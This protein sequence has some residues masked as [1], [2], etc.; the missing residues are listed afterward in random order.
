V[1]R[2]DSSSTLPSRDEILR[3]IEANPEARK[4]DVLEA[5][6]VS[7]RDKVELKRALRQLEADGAIE[8][9]RRRPARRP[10]VARNEGE[11]PPVAVADVVAIDD[12]G[13]L[14]LRAAEQPAA[15][16]LLPTETLE[17]VA[18]RVGDRLL[19]RLRRK[20]SGSYEARLLKLL[21][22]LPREVAG[23][24]E[25][26]ADGLRLRPADRKS[27][28]EYRIA[29]GDA[30][31]AAPGDLVR[32]EVMPSRGY[33]L[34]R[35]K[36]IERLGR[37][38]EPKA[39]SLMVA[40][41]AELPMA[42]SP[43]A[44]AQAAEAKPVELGNRTDLRDVPLVTIDGEDARDFDDAVWAAADDDPANAG[45]HRL[46]VAIADVAWYVRPEDPLDHAAQERGNSVYFPDRVIPML[47][48]ALSNDLCS[49][50]PNEDR[51][52]MAVEM[53]IDSKGKL[54]RHR[55]MRG[56]MRSRAR[57][58]YRQVQRAI[59]GNPDELTGPLL[60]PVIRPLYA[61]Y[62]AL[63]AARRKRGTIELEL[64][65]R[66]VVL[67]EAGL[68]VDIR[69]RERVASHMLIE[70]FMIAANVAAAEALEKAGEVCLYRV[71]DKPD[72]ARLEALA[73][74]LERLGVPW[75][76]A[77]RRPGDFTRLLERLVD[78]ELRDM[79]AGFIL[80]AQA[81]AIYSPRNIGHFGL[82]LKRYAHF[83]SPIRRYSDLI[84]H[85]AL[86]AALRL[87][88]GGV[89]PELEGARLAE[90][91][92]H[93]SRCERRAMEAERR[94]AERYV[95]L[96]MASRVG[97]VFKGRVTGVQ[98]F[99]LFVTL[100][101]S[102][103]E[104]IVPVSTLGDDAFL[105]DERHHALVGQR[106]GETFGLGDIVAVELAEADP[107]VGQLSFRIE[108]HERAHGAEL[109]R[110]AWKKGRGSGRRAP[111]RRRR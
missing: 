46:L 41:Q 23:I 82:H 105:H 109:A 51:A 102:G 93:I 85:R 60:D 89:Q 21:P 25:G 99:G 106:Y 40:V 69:K 37:P 18:P 87:G 20:R 28:T 22:S 98:R 71:H 13:D 5:F 76:A 94:V 15:R 90:L 68:P 14:L 95:A 4:R 108:S 83:T 54:L 70:E 97:A 42:F 80:R 11:L 104:G 52:C 30:A 50:R 96:F 59:D 67:D 8:L 43:E 35:A 16:I 39:L 75:S 1:A 3:W 77:S 49:L 24:I 45:G 44:L 12:E 64:A 26:A 100:D 84:V 33:A 79:I 101:E 31:D 55:F 29:A 61:A 53:R 111:I 103:A 58:T 17:R 56:L 36:V 19:V 57:L 66:Q 88:E 81:Q 92:A 38:D 107:V 73:Q 110:A 72:T 10:A 86:I 34:P 27:R 32:C 7:G 9:R 74:F 91:A 2:D 62:A 78:H 65:E 63:A 6:D 48:E 47:P